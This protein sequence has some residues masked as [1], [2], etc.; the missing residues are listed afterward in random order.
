ML[1]AMQ[2]RLFESFVLALGLPLGAR[3]RA[4]TLEPRPLRFARDHGAH[5]A[6]RIE[7]WYITGQLRAAPSSPP[8]AQ[9]LDP[10]FGFQITFF[11]SR[12]GVDPAHPSRFAASQLM[13]AHAALTDLAARRLQHDQR[14]A[15]RGFG[16]AEFDEADTR[17]SLKDWTLVRAGV[18]DASRYTSRVD[19]AGGFGWQLTFDTT[20]APLLQGDAGWSRKGPRAEQ[21]S[22]YYSQPQLA[23]AGRLTLDGRSV[24]VSGRAWLDHE[25]SDSLLDPEAQGWDWIG[26]NLDDGAALT[27]FRLRRA[28]GS[29]LWAGGSFRR[30]GEAARAFAADAVRF[31]PQRLWASP[32][33]AARYPVQWRVETPAGAFEVVSLLDDQELDSRA[34]TGAIY[35]EGLSELRDARGQRVG[36]GY[37]EMTGYAA[38]LKL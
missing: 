36:L 25:W 16:I 26:I 30:P 9:T 10:A 37:L 34:S 32:R 24:H 29:A 21:A 3:V 28:D 13:F 6:E 18:G 2:R 31:T 11:R 12:T 7:W 19:G 38:P 8:A 4:A 35:W 20:Q 5:P 33:S 17:L 1:A 22:L 27:A 14:V 23:A 15:R